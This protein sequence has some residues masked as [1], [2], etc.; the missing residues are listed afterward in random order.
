MLVKLP[1]GANFTNLFMSSFYAGI[2]RKSKK[3]S[4]IKQLSVPAHIKAV[5]K[6]VDEI[7]P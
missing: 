5:R 7:D 6:H 1:P 4:Q 3:G 2:S